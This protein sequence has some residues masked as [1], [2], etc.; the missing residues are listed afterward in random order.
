MNTTNGWKKSGKTRKCVTYPTV[1][2]AIHGCTGKGSNWRYTIGHFGR[3]E[4]EYACD[5]CMAARNRSDG[6]VGKEYGDVLRTAQ[7]NAGVG[8]YRTAYAKWIDGR[9]QLVGK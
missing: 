4:V 5:T 2:A 9:P 1:W 8:D 3:R 7:A 6:L